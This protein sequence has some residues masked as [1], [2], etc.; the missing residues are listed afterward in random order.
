MIDERNFPCIEP[1]HELYF[2]RRGPSPAE[3]AHWQYQAGARVGGIGI[4]IERPGR[5]PRFVGIEAI[6][7]Q[8]NLLMDTVV[9]EP[10]NRL[11][12][13][14]GREGVTPRNDFV[15]GCQEL[16]HPPPPFR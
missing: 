8:K 2:G 4:K 16:H 5:I 13:D 6:D 1:S 11:P 10:A 15:R 3:S 14:A 12:H 9:S 7:P